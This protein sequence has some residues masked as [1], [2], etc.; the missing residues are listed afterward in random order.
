M[1]KS[2]K[3]KG[4]GIFSEFLD[5]LVGTEMTEGISRATGLD[6]LIKMEEQ[7]MMDRRVTKGPKVLADT[8]TLLALLVHTLKFAAE[9]LLPGGPGGPEPPL[10]P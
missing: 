5:N 6:D 1:P 4:T 2:R 8:A 7:K 9:E 3:I 10:D